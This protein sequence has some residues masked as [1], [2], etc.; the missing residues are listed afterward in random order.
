MVYFSLRWLFVL[1]GAIFAA[2]AI[3]LFLLPNNIIDGGIIGISLILNQLS[4]INFGLLVFIINLPFL[5][6]GYKHLGKGFFIYSLLGIVGLAVTEAILH[7]F[8]FAPI[9][10]TPLLATIFGGLLL[11]IGVGIVIRNGGAMDGT[12]ILSLIITKRLPFTVGECVLVFNLFVFAWAAFVFGIENAMYSVLT[13]YVAAKAIDTVVEGLDATKA[14][15][16]VSSHYEE[17]TTI[18]TQ[19]LGKGVTRLKAQ[20]GYE[21]DKKDVLYVVVKR[22][23]IIQLKKAI[24]AVDKHAFFTIIDAHESRG[25]TFK[26]KEDH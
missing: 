13:Y 14:V 2:V 19:R 22:M 6:I 4:S 7:Q 21:G 20:G 18:I 1:I 10:D 5:Y 17:L 11:G 3:E 26:Q 15:M 12:E 24:Y 25:S 8:H 23:E 9:T 16:I